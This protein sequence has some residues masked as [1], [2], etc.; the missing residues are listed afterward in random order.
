MFGLLPNALYTGHNG[1]RQWLSRNPS[2]RIWNRVLTQAVNPDSS[3]YGYG[4]WEDF[5]GF[6]IGTAV[7]ANVAYYQGDAGGYKSYEDTSQ[8]ILPVQTEV[9]GVIQFSLAATDNVEAWLQLGMNAATTSAP[10]RVTSGSPK[11]LYYEVCFKPGASAFDGGWALG[12]GS[13]NMPANSAFVDDTMVLATASSFLGFHTVDGT[14]KFHWKAASQTGQNISVATL[15]TATW[16]NAGF[17]LDPLGPASTRITIFVNNVEVATKVTDT[18]IAAATFPSGVA[19]SPVLGIK[20]GTAEART[21]D[22]DWYGV[23]QGR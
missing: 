7:A 2:P 16:V 14:L 6:G 5:L 10:Y 22:V 15:T 21:L 13:V 19:L 4:V 18:N 9:G 11:P 3:G 17:Y 1:T 23:W 20:N 12:L 8:T